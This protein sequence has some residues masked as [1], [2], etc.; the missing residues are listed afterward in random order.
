MCG[1]RRGYVSHILVRIAR[2]A[3]DFSFVFADGD[4]LRRILDELMR[5]EEGY[6][7]FLEHLYTWS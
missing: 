1:A 3:E 2:W 4:M 5:S 7:L 6:P